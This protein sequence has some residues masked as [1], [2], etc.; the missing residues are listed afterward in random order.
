MSEQRRILVPTDFSDCSTEAIRRAGLLAEKFH[1]QVHVLHLMEPPAYFE[2]DAMSVPLLEDVD[3]A[4]HKEEL[5]RLKKQAAACEM[6]VVLHLKTTAG[7]A[8]RSLCHFAKLLPADLIVM[9]HHRETSLKSLL[10]GST[11]KRVVANAPCSVLV[12]QPHDLFVQ[13]IG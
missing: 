10:A 9:G 11:T 1:A 8:A 6:Q 5:R 12:I 2:T 4:M 3:H 13:A 7:D